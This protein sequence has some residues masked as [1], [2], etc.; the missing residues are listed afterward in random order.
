[1]GEKGMNI[2]SLELEYNPFFYILPSIGGT[3]GKSIRISIHWLNLSITLKHISL[4]YKAKSIYF[5][6]PSVTIM[7]YPS[8][9]YLYT[10]EIN[11]FGYTY[12]KGLIRDESKEVS[13]Y[14][15]TPGFVTEEWFEQFRDSTLTDFM[16][17]FD[18]MIKKLK[19]FFEGK[20]NEE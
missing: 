11:A 2:L 5:S 7:Q 9:A 10:F 13:P 16:D 19:E 1:M 20:N 8:S 12:R 18:E 3:L 17:N 14:D 15:N 4:D 6:T